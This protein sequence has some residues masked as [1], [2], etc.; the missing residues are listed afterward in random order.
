MR[1][2]SGAF[3]LSYIAALL[4]PAVAV[5]L[6]WALDPWL[7]DRLALATLYAA[8]GL[9]VWIGGYRPAVISTIL[10][11]AACDWLFIE[12]RGHFAFLEHRNLVG[13]F[14][15][16]LSCAVIIGFG[17]G[18]RRASRRAGE[19]REEVSRILQGIVDDRIGAEEALRRS[20]EA[21]RLLVAL[22][23]ATRGLTDPA[24]VLWEIVNRVG[25][26]FGVSRCTYGEID[27]AQEHVIV[28]RDSV[29]GVPS[30][31]GR[32]QLD[33][34]G[35]A[36]I[37]ELKAG[38]TL[39]VADVL[40]DPRTS[41]PV[42]AAAHDGIQARSLLCVPLVKEGRFVAVLALHHNEPRDW[43]EDDAT[44]ME[45][46]AERTWFAVEGAR[47]EAALRE[48]RDVLSLAMRG[49]RMGAWSRNL[50]TGE[51]WWSREL[52]EIFG[53]EPGGFQGDEDGF[54][55]FL[56]EDDRAEVL[57]AVE[58]ALATHEDY[59]IEFRFWHPSG[60]YRWMEGRGRAV[61]GAD[62]RPVMLYGLAIDITQRKRAE[63]ALREANRR[64]DDFLATLAHELRNPLAPI[65]TATE[66]L[67]I[68]APPHGELRAVRDIIDR[69]VRQMTRLV[70]D[71]LDVARI[72]RGKIQLRKDR[73]ELAAVVSDAVEAARPL[74]AASGHEL[75][76]A[77]PPD[78]VQLDADPTR[79]SQILLNLLNNAAKYTPRGG[80]IRLA[81]ER[82]GAAVT[83]SVRDNGIGIAP[84]HLPHVFEMFSQVTPALERSEGGLGIGL[85][86]VRGLLELHGGSIEARSDGP[87]RGSEFIVRL[88]AVEA[89]AAPPRE[90]TGDEAWHQGG[91]R[92]RILVVD[93]NQDAADSLSLM[94]QLKGHD[95][96]TAQDGLQGVQIAEEYRPDLVLLDIGMP[97]MNGYEAARH[98]R[99]QPWGQSM[100]LVALTGWGHEDDKRRAAEAGFDHHLTKPVEHS[101]IEA[102][103][104][105]WEAGA[106]DR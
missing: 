1:G 8:V 27:A 104:Q 2:K 66:I 22:H 69:Q 46:V 90:P 38:R 83:V 61:Y 31:V 62:G 101:R 25:R 64:K 82:E 73:V 14:L 18:M 45:Q 60:E 17:E 68:K 88:P 47:A 70:D 13:L 103:L 4:F 19:S 80:H 78:P 99:Q 15:Y 7:G 95:I 105:A 89:P 5:L 79:L 30:I 43:T 33:Q 32:H 42:V 16:L 48:S 53:L 97:K 49:G 100:L 91:P 85:A 72:T 94:L 37:R 11:Y 24:E 75:E 55:A 65:R 40:A 93:D 21:H 59:A 74:L 41:D 50:A 57:R 71:L 44:L 96:R 102:L 67:R 3:V 36:V 77:L 20:D 92:R 86:L 81:A 106:R 34:F 51:V 63:D 26:H 9:V 54:T 29:D 39:A 56:H 28:T 76:V 35:P 58:T 52:E 98:I 6:R 87:G 23:D 84:E 10:G 12:P